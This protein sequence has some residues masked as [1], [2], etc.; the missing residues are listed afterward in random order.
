MPRPN[1]LRAFPKIESANTHCSKTDRLAN[2]GP[3]KRLNPNT[4][5]LVT[6]AR[7]IQIFSNY[8]PTKSCQKTSFSLEFIG[9]RNTDLESET[10]SVYV[11]T[12]PYQTSQK[13]NARFKINLGI[14]KEL[15]IAFAKLV[16]INKGT[17]L[18]SWI[19]TFAFT[20]RHSSH[21]FSNQ[22]KRN[23]DF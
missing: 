8:S 18:G 20:S 9:T 13:Q 21:I 16:Y 14:K 3:T 15:G 22:L 5:W 11:T 10:S 17:D 12:R 6:S 7:F 19:V 23:Y 4:K 1:L 2:Y